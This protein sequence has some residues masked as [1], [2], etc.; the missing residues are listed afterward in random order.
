MIQQKVIPVVS[1]WKTL[2][3]FLKHPSTWCVVMDVHIN[4]MEEVLNQ[5][6]IHHKK[7]LVHMDLVKGIQNDKFG[8]EFLCQ[9]YHVDGIIS[10]K[11]AVI[12]CAKKQHCISVL[13]V[14]LIDSRSVEK[15]GL[16]AHEL[17]PDYVEV[18]PAIL[19]FAV[20]AMRKY[21]DAAIIGGGLIRN[22]ED[23]EQC[24]KQGMS[25]IT[26]SQL[27]LCEEDGL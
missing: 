24:L 22:R 18:L 6:H 26:T 4:L 17:Q 10:T 13:R 3:R 15:G 1:D 23:V 19:P 7:A 9:K 5:L 21:C 8:V 14:F 16:L 20:E 12:E 2:I 27:D 11:P 25:A